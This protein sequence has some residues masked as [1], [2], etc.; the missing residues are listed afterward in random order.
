MS[1]DPTDDAILATISAGPPE[2]WEQLWA[3]VDE[4]LR[5]RPWVRWVPPVRRA[6]GVIQVGYPVYSDE[7][8]RVERAL[9]EL[10]AIVPFDWL[11]W[12]GP[13]RYPEG[14]G[15]DRA[16]A[17]DAVRMLTGIFRSE[18]FCDGSIDG[19]MRSG[20]LPRA[21]LRLRRWY[22]DER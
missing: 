4:L 8:D 12:D 22:D 16:P 20:M 11:H 9:Y 18:R 21:L 13:E 1:D 10:G 3:A 19:C 2:A 7:M 14:L 5:E 6:D 17:A 15:L